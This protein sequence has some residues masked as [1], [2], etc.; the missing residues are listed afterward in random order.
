MIKIL[1]VT[2]LTL[3]L[4]LATAAL[5]W[6]EA[7]A[8]AGKAEI[9][10]VVKGDNAF[11]CDLYGHLRAKDGN[12]F[13]SPYS[14]STALAMTYAGARGQTAEEM[15]RTLHFPLDQNKLHEAFRQL[16][17]EI[18]AAGEHRPYEL[19]VANALWGQQGH[20][21]LREFIDCTKHC[22]G[23][24]LREVDFA[25]ATEQARQAINFWVE[26]Q[27]NKKIKDLI[28]PGVLDSSARLVLTNAIYF[29]SH[30]DH[31]FPESLTKPEDFQAAGAK[32]SVPTMHQTHDCSY[33]DGDTFQMLE[34]PYQWYQ[35]QLTMQILLPRKSDGVADLEKMLTAEKLAEWQ[36]K[37]KTHEV[38][39]A[40]PKFKFSAEFE[41]SPTLA[42]MGMPTAFTYPKADFSGMDGTR[43][44]YIGF[45][46]HQAYVDVHEKGT[47]AAAAT[48]IGVKA[49]AAPVSF[50]K[51]T[52][53]ADHPFV[54]LIR[55]RQTG[56][57]L[58]MGR[59]M[60]PKA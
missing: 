41:L 43:E 49:G 25:K 14:I 38:D 54:F 59:M 26:D 52:F 8:P 32:V 7:K 44:L 24:G 30:W 39:I 47:E 55:D 3:T 13:F 42:K 5:S 27:T 6:K 57:V 35:K 1:L 22:Y 17:A 58:F 19:S 50:P 15:A 29:K 12:I 16:Q 11:A 34:L 51:A 33:F 53:R 28:K 37:M 18:N 56:S 9:A 4:T 2:M 10:A 60:N 36:S 48:A 23:A 40:L 46:I 45:V 20:S 21:F 31:P